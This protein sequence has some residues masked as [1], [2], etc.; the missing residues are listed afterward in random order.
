MLI[1]SVFYSTKKKR[2]TGN[3]THSKN[4]AVWRSL[5]NGARQ[6]WSIP[7]HDIPASSLMLSPCDSQ[8]K[9]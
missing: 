4:S 5:K 9:I 1:N 8:S 6:N 3:S 2:L 7:P